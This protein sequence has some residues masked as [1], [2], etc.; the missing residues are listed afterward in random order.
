MGWGDAEQA[1]LESSPQYIKLMKAFRLFDKNGDGFIDAKELLDLLTRMTPNADPNGDGKSMT[2]QDAEWIINSFDDNGDGKLSI[3]E[4]VAAWSTIGGSDEALA[5]SMKE[6]RDE[7]QAAIRKK[8]AE[9]AAQGNTDEFKAKVTGASTASPA[10]AM[11]NSHG[12][13]V[14][15]TTTATAAPEQVQPE[16]V[17]EEQPEHLTAAQR[18]RRAASAKLGKDVVEGAGSFGARKAQ[19]EANAANMTA[20]ERAKLKAK[21]EL[22]KKEARKKAAKEAAKAAK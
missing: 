12:K 15:P 22:A 7:K 1:Q 10:P 11:S 5:K 8:Q 2:I 21:E 20:A 16:V 19:E 4:L 9:S 3:E 17:A 18:A 14:A 6:K 13:S